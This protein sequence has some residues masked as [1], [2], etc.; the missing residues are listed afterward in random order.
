MQVMDGDKAKSD[1]CVEVDPESSS[2]DTADTA[3]KILILSSF[4]MP[5]KSIITARNEVGV[6]LCFHR[7]V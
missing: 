3:T 5:L 1:F 2:K 6:R 4:A 7:R